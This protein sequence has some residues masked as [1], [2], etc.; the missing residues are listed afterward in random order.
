V[1]RRFRIRS[2]QYAGRYAGPTDTVVTTLEP[3]ASREVKVAGTR[4]S[5]YEHKRDATECFKANAETAQKQ[6]KNLGY[7]SELIPVDALD[8]LVGLSLFVQ[9]GDE[10]ILRSCKAKFA[11]SDSDR[12]QLFFGESDGTND[13][14]V[15]KTRQS[16]S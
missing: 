15:E 13:L 14:F 11:G 6:L 2:G 10:R 9:N 7:D 4:Y 3:T 12:I 16:R 5:F 1:M 8:S